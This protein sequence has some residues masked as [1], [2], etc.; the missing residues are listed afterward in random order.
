MKSFLIKPIVFMLL[1]SLVITGC[2]SGNSQFIT[3]QSH[4]ST[5]PAKTNMLISLR[6]GEHSVSSHLEA[7]HDEQR[8]KEHYE[9]NKNELINKHTEIKSEYMD[10]VDNLIAK[11]PIGIVGQNSAGK[12]DLIDSSKDG[13]SF[14]QFFIDKNIKLP[15]KNSLKKFDGTPI[16]QTDKDT[17]AVIYKD[18]TNSNRILINASLNYATDD[19]N[20]KELFF[21]IGKSFFKTLTEKYNYSQ[22][23]QDFV[24]LLNTFSSIDG[25]KELL[26]AI[27]SQRSEAF[28][29]IFT[30]LDSKQLNLDFLLNN[31]EVSTNL[32]ASIFANCQD[33]NSNPNSKYSFRNLWPEAAAFMLE[34]VD[35]GQK[36]D[37]KINNPSLEEAFVTISDQIKLNNYFKTIHQVNIKLIEPVENEDIAITTISSMSEDPPLAF[38]YASIAGLYKIGLNGRAHQES[39]IKD[40]DGIINVLYYDRL[41]SFRLYRAARNNYAYYTT[42]LSRII[43]DGSIPSPI[44]V[45]VGSCRAF[46]TLYHLEL[47]SNNALQLNTYS[48][49]FEINDE[50]SINTKNY[51]FFLPSPQLLKYSQSELYNKIIEAF[52]TGDKEYISVIHKNKKTDKYET[53]TVEPMLKMIKDKKTTEINEADFKKFQQKWLSKYSQIKKDREFMNDKN[54]INRYMEFEQYRL[55]QLA[56]SLHEF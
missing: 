13:S 22:I 42:A 48:L 53:Y 35:I 15:E 38:G 55:N 4:N 17:V 21:Q 54:G 23:N 25:D 51:H 56:K 14:D 11:L 3:K 16:D 49:K 33:S 2:N 27:I 46:G 18:D 45:D 1:S 8:N 24:D 26:K 39:L 7:F 28:N 10:T 32:L 43:L 6:A 29:E 5:S 20:R 47:L 36:I 41:D 12:L 37:F 40:K 30:K 19:N 50:V 34:K 44:K 9:K 31:T 52:V